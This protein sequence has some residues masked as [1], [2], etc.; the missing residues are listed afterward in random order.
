MWEASLT[1]EK[2]RQAGI[3]PSLVRIAAGLENAAD[4]CADMTQALS[5]IRTR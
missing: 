2:M 4:L 5:G 1:P 3:A